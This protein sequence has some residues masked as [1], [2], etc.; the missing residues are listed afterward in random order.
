MQQTFVEINLTTRPIV[1][2]PHRLLASILTKSDSDHN[3]T[4]S[5]RDDFSENL[6]QN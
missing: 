4:T 3:E 5:H 6:E 2:N 1:K